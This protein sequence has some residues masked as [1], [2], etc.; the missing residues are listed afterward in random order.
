M[1]NEQ[2]DEQHRQ[3]DDRVPE[4]RQR[5][6]RAPAAQEYH[7]TTQETDAESQRADQVNDPAHA[8]GDR[9][10]ADD[11]QGDG[12]VEDM[13]PGIGVAVRNG[14]HRHVDSLVVPPTVDGQRPE[15][16]RCPNEDD[17][18][19]DDAAPFDGVGHGGPAEQRWCRAEQAADDD[20]LRRRALQVE[21]VEKPVADPRDEVQARRE[22]VDPKDQDHEPHDAKCRREDDP[23]H[24]A[25]PALG[26]RPVP[27]TRHA[28]VDPRIRDVIDHRRGTRDQG[29]AHET[30]QDNGYRGHTRRREQHAGQRAK[31]H[32]Q[33]DARLG[34][35]QV[36][37]PGSRGRC[38]FTHLPP[39]G[40]TVAPFASGVQAG[41]DP[42][43]G[44]HCVVPSAQAALARLAM[45]ARLA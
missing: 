2:R 4:G 6:A 13:P 26:Y 40:T 34:Q 29:D 28:G 32:Q 8:D 19:Q 44:G 15:V 25:D 24:R 18:Q 27:G 20:V 10:Q 30:E 11:A 23:G 45:R 7:G 14:Q 43:T 16:R 9:Q 36:V 35:F 3:V 17:Q 5:R 37:S 39:P 12:V 22:R 41:R 42:P 21:G 33:H 1:V 31:Q 38:G